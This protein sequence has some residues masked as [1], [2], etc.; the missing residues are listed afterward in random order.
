MKKKALML[1]MAAVFLL[2]PA[3]MTYAGVS[4]TTEQKM[5]KM[6]GTLCMVRP[7][8][9]SPRYGWGS[10]KAGDVGKSQGMKGSDL[11]IDFPDH[12]GW[13]ADPAEMIPVC[14][15]GMIVVRGPDWKWGS[16]DGGAGKKGK[17]ITAI[18]EDGWIEVK[19]D[20]GDSNMYRWNIEGGKYDLRAIDYG[21]WVQEGGDVSS[22]DFTYKIQSWAMYENA[23]DGSLYVYYA[24]DKDRNTLFV[25]PKESTGDFSIRTTLGYYAFD[26]DMTGSKGGSAPDVLGVPSSATEMKNGLVSYGKWKLVLYGNR[27]IIT[28]PDLDYAFCIPVDSNGW[29]E[30]YGGDGS[31]RT[32]W[33]ADKF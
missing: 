2:M 33:S 17:V 6:A 9:S 12:S 3:L 10:V 23:D 8:I 24:D 21:T 16:Q 11:L 15:L 27:L 7:E 20:S 32:V 29:W 5:V 18:D 1:A 4:T 22:G 26:G 13:Y 31:V 19:W 14:E 30:L 28:H 25:L